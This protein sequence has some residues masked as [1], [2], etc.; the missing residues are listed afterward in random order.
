MGT[1]ITCTILKADGSEVTKI[2]HATGAVNQ[3]TTEKTFTGYKDGDSPST[4]GAMT[5]RKESPVHA[6]LDQKHESE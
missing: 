4:A 3:T 2:Y 5:L 1:K 6:I